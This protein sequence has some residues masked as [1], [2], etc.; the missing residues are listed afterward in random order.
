M[1]TLDWQEADGTFVC[2]GYRIERVTDRQW[3]LALDAARTRTSVS[4]HLR[5]DPVFGSLRSARAAALHFEVTRVRQIKLVRH[6]ALAVVTFILAVVFYFVMAS[7]TEATRLEWFV[8][9][10]V[11]LVL[12]LS[13]SLDAFVLLVADGW[14][15]RYE[16]PRLSIVDRMVS[17]AVIL[18]LWPKPPVAVDA[19]PPARVQPLT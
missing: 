3:L 15:Y 11:A 16:V 19:E 10:G 7:G 8:L 14:D 13:E 2:D 12:A 4:R 6:V 1:T 17:S 5:R 18:T 9:A